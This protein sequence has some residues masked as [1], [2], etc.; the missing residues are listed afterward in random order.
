MNIRHVTQI[1]IL[2]ANALDRQAVEILDLQR[3]RIGEHH[4]VGRFD[5]LVACRKHN[6]LPAKGLV[7]VRRR[8]IMRQQ[9][10]LVERDK[11]LLGHAAIGLRDDCAGDGHQERSNIVEGQIEHRRRRQIFVGDLKHRHRH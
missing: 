2:I 10:L 1:D 8:E 5:F 3:S 11:Q 4:P 7:N 6:I 9:L